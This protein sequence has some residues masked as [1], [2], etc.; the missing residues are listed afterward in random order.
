MNLKEELLGVVGAL[1]RA[2]VSYA[3]CG[4]MAV[5]LHGH[6]RLTRN[7]D[8]LVRPEDLPAAKAAL[9]TV[10]F[11][12]EAGTIP[13]DLGKPHQREVCRISKAVGTD[14]ITLDLLLLP[15]FL[16]EVWTSRE[17][18]Q[19]E[20]A[21]VTVVSRRGLVQMKKAAGRPQDLGDVAALEGEAE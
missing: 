3:L 20:G 16:E 21:Q 5:V 10:G 7:I 17:T 8:L 9:A 12:I 13:F 4:G 2:A 19:V 6:P 11:T 15:E 18:Y 1:N 14:L